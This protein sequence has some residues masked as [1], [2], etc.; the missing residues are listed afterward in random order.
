LNPFERWRLGDPAIWLRV[1]I[2]EHGEYNIPNNLVAS[3]KYFKNSGN[4]KI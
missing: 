4:G 2:L 3:P 1:P